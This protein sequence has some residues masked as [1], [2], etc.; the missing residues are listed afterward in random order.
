MLAEKFACIW[1]VILN[2]PFSLVPFSC[3]NSKY[4][5]S[6]APQSTRQIHN[7]TAQNVLAN[8]VTETGYHRKGSYARGP[9][10]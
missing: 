1:V 6:Y 2:A 5:T 4:W 7:V 9:L 10:E 3:G 8:I